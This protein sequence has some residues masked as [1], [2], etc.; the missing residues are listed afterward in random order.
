MI[1]LVV[2]HI[3]LNDAN[4]GIFEV[5][6]LGVGLG[7]VIIEKDMCTELRFAESIELEMI[8]DL[9]LRQYDVSEC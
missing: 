2:I 7:D 4:Y 6:A 5:K 1:N 3:T 9:V 8:N